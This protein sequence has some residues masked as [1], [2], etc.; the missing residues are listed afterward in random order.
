VIGLY[1]KDEDELASAKREYHFFLSSLDN[2]EWS[3]PAGKT[4]ESTQ[5][6]ARVMQAVKNMGD[7][8]V[9]L[10]MIPTPERL[11]LILTT[12][13]SMRS[14]KSPVSQGELAIKVAEFRKLLEDPGSDVLPPAKELY[15]ILIAPL[16]EELDRAGTKTLMLSLNGVLRYIPMAALH[17]GDKWLAEKY[18]TALYTGE[19]DGKTEYESLNVELMTLTGIRT[20]ARFS[21]IEENDLS[22]M[23]FGRRSKILGNRDRA[24]QEVEGLGIWAGRLGIKSVVASLWQSTYSAPVFSGKL[25]KAEALRRLQLDLIFMTNEDSSVDYHQ[26]TPHPEDF[27]HPFYWAGYIVMGND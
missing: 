22:E 17:D 16:A 2:A 20:K 24:G 19:N 7:G 9:L 14:V 1:T 27:R 8:V 10:Q 11:W 23:C 15:G 18:A 5:T 26:L 4:D 13:D 21:V 6:E 12:P 25:S 3:D